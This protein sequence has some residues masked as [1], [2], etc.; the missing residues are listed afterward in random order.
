MESS[1]LPTKARLALAVTVEVDRVKFPLA[2]YCF[3][4]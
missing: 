1:M 3:I 2:M 4:T